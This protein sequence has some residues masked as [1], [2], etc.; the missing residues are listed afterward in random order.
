MSRL[1]Y[2]ND[3]F[4]GLQELQRQ[5]KFLKEDGYLR[6]FGAL[7]NN[8]GIA[9]VDSDTNFDNFKVQVG[10][11]SG[12]FKIAVDSVALDDEL[13]IIYQKAI[14]NVAITDD[15]SWY[16]VKISHQETNIEEGTINI[17][18]DGSV[19]GF[20]TSF[21]DVLRDQNDYPVKVNFPNSVINTGDYQ[22]V[23]ILSNSSA[24]F[25]GDFTDENNL[26]YRVIGSFTPGI[27]P[28]GDDRLPYFYDSTNIE[29]IAETVVDTPPSK[30]AGTEF[31]LA[32]VQNSGGVVTVQDKRT[33]ILSVAKENTGW[34]EPSLGVEFTNVVGREVE[35]R[36]NYIGEIEVRGSFTTTLG[37]ANLF[38]LP[39]GFRPP[40]TIQGFYGYDDATVIRII[41]VTQAGVVSAS[42]SFDFSTSDTNEIISL[43][44]KTE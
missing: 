32:R 8:F 17:T 22:V 30:V 25:S 14:D 43:R 12:T 38:T 33:E 24:I 9:N 3:L 16:W 23:S 6:I 41:T 36:K 39:V 10:T 27:S 42:S 34:I 44:F 15:S 40:Y 18:A 5:D 28:S 31:Y 4:L 20:G 19:S 35:Y 37:T 2:Q 21:V 7:I 11:N 13:N 26:E 1:N 29:L